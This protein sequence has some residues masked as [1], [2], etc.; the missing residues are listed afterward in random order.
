[1]PDDGPVAHTPVSRLDHALAMVEAIAEQRSALSKDD[2]LRLR[3]AVDTLETLLASEGVAKSKRLKIDA[4]LRWFELE[5]EVRVSLQ[6]RGPLRLLFKAL[7]E[8]HQRAAGSATTLNELFAAGWPGQRTTPESGAARVYVALAT[9]RR[10]GLRPLLQTRDDGY[11]IEPSVVV[12]VS[13][14]GT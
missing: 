13:S 3:R 10:L 2:R 12:E 7:I 14:G 5:G 4:D 9:L 11:L 6:R 8:R 1:M